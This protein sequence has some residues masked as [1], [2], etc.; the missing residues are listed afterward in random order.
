MTPPATGIGCIVLAAGTGSRFGSDKRQ[1][2]LGGITLLEQSLNTIAPLFNKRLLVLRPGDETLASGFAPFWQVLFASE[3]LKGMGHSLAA[4][5]AGTHDWDG[6]VIALADMP[7]VQAATFCA[8]RDHL[9]ADTLVVPCYQGRRGNPV[10]IGR[11]FFAELA[12]LQGDQGARKLLEQHAG[13]VVRLTVDDPG[14]LRD[15]DTPEALATAQGL[16]EQEI[17]RG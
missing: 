15:I 16:A 6:A 7:L 2:R 13:A 11:Q 8:I 10:G 17:R 14:I 5:M 3:A 12:C 1:A 9:A 4:A